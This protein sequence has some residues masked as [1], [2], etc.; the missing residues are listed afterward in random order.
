MTTEPRTA[1]TTAWVDL[2][3]PDPAAAAAFYSALLGWATE[4]DDTPMGTYTVGRVAAGPVG[5][6]MAPAPDAEGMPPMWAVFF[7]TDDIEAACARAEAAGA[8]TL[9]PPM[10]V[11][12]GDRIAVVADP[13]GATVGLMQPAAGEPLAYGELGTVC[14]VETDSRDPEAS[15]TFY[16]TVFGWT[17]TGD[18]DGY[19]VFGR[20]G[21]QV[22]GLMAMPAEVPEMVPSYWLVY[23]KVADV[24]QACQATTDLGGAIVA[25]TMEVEGMRF[26]V[27]TDPAGAVFGLLSPL[28]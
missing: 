25:P 1:G 12:G 11:P 8:T 4:T 9:Q 20:N 5:G 23:F 14:W 28:V 13:A 3:T 10:E 6:M 21:D 24:D 2:S 27:A 22:G 26:A 15:K 17:T 16:E 18:A 7:A 19:R